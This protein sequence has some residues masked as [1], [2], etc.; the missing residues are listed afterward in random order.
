MSSLPAFENDQINP[1]VN[2]WRTAGANHIAQPTEY[3]PF[4]FGN[5]FGSNQHETGFGSSIATMTNNNLPPEISN[6]HDAQPGLDQH[7]YSLYQTPA[8]DDILIYFDDDAP[9]DFSGNFPFSNDHVMQDK[10]VFLL[11]SLI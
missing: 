7:P 5:G 9:N 1:S 10:V 3:T 4:S 2:G 6:L 8:F 11:N